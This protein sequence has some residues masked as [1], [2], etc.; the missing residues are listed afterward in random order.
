MDD[1]DKVWCEL[2][3]PIPSD[4]QQ[5]WGLPE[6]LYLPA[7]T[8]YV[9][10]LVRNE[11]GKVI[12]KPRLSQVGEWGEFCTYPDGS[13]FTWVINAQV[14]VDAVG[15][16]KAIKG[17]IKGWGEFGKARLNPNDGR[18]TLGQFEGKFDV[19]PE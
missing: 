10:P 18:P 14:Y 2:V 16:V 19:R 8:G 11:K 3:I 4:I 9:G 7:P 13:Y 12:N 17:D 15:T 5:Q 6:V 1:P